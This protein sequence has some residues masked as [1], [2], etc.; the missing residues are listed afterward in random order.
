M[1][2][3]DRGE[4]KGGLKE[5]E[6]RRAYLSGSRVKHEG[7]KGTQRRASSEGKRTKRG[8]YQEGQDHLR[9]EEFLRGRLRKR[10]DL[11]PSEIRGGESKR[12][13]FSSEREERSGN[14]SN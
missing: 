11:L 5:G 14:R 6:S 8:S 7:K 12:T 2:E 10:K 4:K 9:E 13:S 3:F 1:G